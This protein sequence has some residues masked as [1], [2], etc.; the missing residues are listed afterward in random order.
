MGDYTGLAALGGRVY[1]AWTEKP[2]ARSRGT[3]IR[4]GVADFGT[5]GQ[6]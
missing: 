4:V 6:P 5:G 1:G 2:E 3:V